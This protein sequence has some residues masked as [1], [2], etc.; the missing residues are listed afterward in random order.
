MHV[1]LG[2]SSLPPPNSGRGIYGASLSE[3]DALVGQIKRVADSHGK[4][5]TLL[6]FAGTA[7]KV[8]AVAGGDTGGH[9]QGVGGGVDRTPVCPLPLVLLAVLGMGRE[10]QLW[11][12]CPGLS[13]RGDMGVSWGH[14][15]PGVL[16]ALSQ[17][18][19]PPPRLA[20]GLNRQGCA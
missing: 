5:H 4:G 14:G 8:A 2:V 7:A 1:P 18:L 19:P 13:H 9:S 6:W 3:M 10:E 16:G 11:P 12:S 20:A 17:L 15:G